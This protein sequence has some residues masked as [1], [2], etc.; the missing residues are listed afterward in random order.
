MYRLKLG[1]TVIT[2]HTNGYNEETVV[3]RTGTSLT[4]WE[5]GGGCR[6]RELWEHQ[7][8]NSQGEMLK[9]RLNK[10]VPSVAAKRY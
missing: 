5:F 2:I 7:I 3:S 4:L 6:I 9:I 8:A 1:E 10:F